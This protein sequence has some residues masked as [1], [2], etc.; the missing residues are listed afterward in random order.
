MLLAASS[1]RSNFSRLPCAPELQA[2]VLTV[3]WIE[4]ST[5]ILVARWASPVSE[6]VEQ[7]SR[8]DREEDRPDNLPRQPEDCAAC[9][10]L[11]QDRADDDS[12]KRD[13][14]HQLVAT[15]RRIEL[16]ELS[17]LGLRVLQGCPPDRGST[18]PLSRRDT[19]ILTSG[20]D[21][22]LTNA[23]CSIRLSP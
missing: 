7:T 19:R 10:I 5:E 22:S 23:A 12:D 16:L 3:P 8:H 20:L 2:A 4:G 14:N 15:S 13:A 11:G 17:L 9:A 6:R 21:V 18:F 1:L